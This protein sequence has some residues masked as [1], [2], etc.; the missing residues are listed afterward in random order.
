MGRLLKVGVVFLLVFLLALVATMKV[1][2]TNGWFNE[3]KV[4]QY[5]PPGLSED[6]LK[7]VDDYSEL[8]GASVLAKDKTNQYIGYSFLNPRL[9]K[10]PMPYVGLTMWN[11]WNREGIAGVKN[12][13]PEYYRAYMEGVGTSKNPELAK[14]E[15]E[16]C[17][18]SVS[19]IDWARELFNSFDYANAYKMYV[20]D[21]EHTRYPYSGD[22]AAQMQIWGWGTPKNEE[23]GETM[24][25]N[26]CL[27]KEHYISCV[28]LA[29]HYLSKGDDA[30]N[31]KKAVLSIQNMYD[32]NS[33][34]VW[35]R[36]NYMGVV[37]NPGYVNSNPREA[38]LKAMDLC[39]KGVMKACDAYGVLQLTSI[40]G[41]DARKRAEKEFRKACD[42]G[43]WRGCY[44]LS[45]IDGIISYKYDRPEA[46]KFYQKGCTAG[47]IVA[48]VNLARIWWEFLPAP[49]NYEKAK[50]LLDWGCRKGDDL[51]CQPFGPVKGYDPSLN[52]SPIGLT[53]NFFKRGCDNGNPQ[54][55][56]MN[57]YEKLYLYSDKWDPTR[58]TQ[59]LAGHLHGACDKGVPA[60]CRLL[61]AV[62][63]NY[64][65]VN[66]NPVEAIL[67]EQNACA[68][69]VEP[70]CM[71]KIP[72]AAD[73]SLRDYF[74][75]M[76]EVKK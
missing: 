70:G 31:A 1:G 53:G 76:M 54:Y 18:G 17:E 38:S 72:T 28:R 43:E 15:A 50:K 26:L 46:E 12:Q 44:H 60:A 23:A 74:N 32:R 49:T 19:C 56:A 25:Q 45:T 63:M 61:G 22:H 35:L 5:A 73:Q 6:E 29:F 64:G 68:M 47:E 34:D 33:D 9:F 59:D 8:M 21:F 24:L 58:Y 48:C 71:G 7:R 39:N 69:T 16:I 55:C 14:K 62:I 65:W 51:S 67:R 10:D 42:N 36:N 3:A 52:A 4:R 57:A 40:K 11:V 30:T 20:A 27:D 75:K 2:S 66:I 37:L 41:G 13:R